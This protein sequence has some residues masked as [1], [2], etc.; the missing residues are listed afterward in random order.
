MYLSAIIK[1]PFFVPKYYTDYFSHCYYKFP[2]KKQ[3]GREG[4]LGIT[5][6]GDR[7]HGG[8]SNGL[9]VIPTS[10]VRKPNYQQEVGQGYKNPKACLNG[11][12]PQAKFHLIND[13][14]P[15]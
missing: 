1:S 13:R 5:I 12:L 4:L 6:K 8:R 14:K 11:L 3:L 10:T 7:S 15:P 2:D 9:L